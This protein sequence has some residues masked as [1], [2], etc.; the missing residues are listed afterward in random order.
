MG[1]SKMRVATTVKADYSQT[2]SSVIRIQRA[3]VTESVAVVQ[4]QLVRFDATPRISVTDSLLTSRNRFS[5]H[6]AL[7]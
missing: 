6:V 2:G 7:V 4:V 1:E 5:P 3:M